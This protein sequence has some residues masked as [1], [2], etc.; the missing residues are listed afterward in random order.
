MRNLVFALR[1]LSKSPI[2]SIVAILSLALGIGANTAIFSLFEQSLLRNLPVHNPPELVNLTANGPR[3]GSNSTN[4]AGNQQSIFSYAMYRDLEKNQTVFTGIAAHRSFGAN[5]AYQGQTTS[6]SG[7]F[8]S[9]SYFPILG[10]KP[11][12]GRLLNFDDDK[13]PGSH[14][15]AVLSHR[16]W[17]EKF[18]A[19]P[20]VIGTAMVVNGVLMT[21]IGVG[22]EGFQGTTLGS[23][24]SVFVPISMREALTPGWK[25]LADR[26]SYWV[27][28]FA[29]L[30]SGT[31]MEKAQSSMQATYIG[32]IRDTELV[33]QKGMS[34]RTRKQF[35]E[36]QMTLTDGA[37]GQSG[38]LTAG[39]TPM[40]LLFAIAGFVLLIACANIANLLLARSANRAK[41]F[42]IRLSLGAS[43]SQLIVQLLCEALVLA[44]FAGI[45]GILVSYATGQVILGF[46]PTGAD[47]IFNSGIRPITVVFSMVV[48]IIAGFL[49]GLFPATHATKID[50]SAAMK[51][52]AG[53]V[54]STASASR[55]RRSLVT[56]QIALSLLLL[57]SAGMFLK[58]LTKILQVDLGMRTE[59]VIAF[60]LS[61]D[62]NQY[63]PERS[64]AF[65]EQ[66]E[67]KVAAIPGVQAAS[68]SLVGM[69]AGNN[70]GSSVSV[71][72]FE[73]GPDTDT[74]SM[75]NEV[76][77]GFFRMMN[78]PMVKGREFTASDAPSAPKV[79][80][81]NE[82]F[83]KKF[84]NG[85]SLLGRRMQQ[86][87]GGKNDIEIVG[88][89]KNVK[90]SEVKDEIPPV[91]YTPYRQDPR[92]GSSAFYIACALPADQILPS[93]R[94][95]VAEL[96]PNLP[97]EDVKTLDAQIKEN[98]GIDRMISTLAAAF[99]SL[100][101]LL[102]AV[103][104]YGVLAFTVAR[105]TREIGIRLAIGA[106][107][108]TV[109]NMILKEVVWMLAIGVLLGLPAAIA[110]MRYAE[111]LLFEIKSGDLWVLSCS[112]FVVCAV[113]L[114]AGFLPAR[115]AMQ[116]TPMEALRYE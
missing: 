71:D 16:Y 68:V 81:V 10:I 15:L 27:Y 33:L 51:D 88:V 91:F 36:Q 57:I 14:R 42:S 94:R 20:E 26:R 8:V 29:R 48:S 86:G 99:A 96:D 64:R 59:N 78:V 61:P 58:S 1:T 73:V 114:L 4:N 80:V 60:G 43:R 109:R 106:D 75:Y 93:V 87:G 77:A 97:L 7:M 35:V 74:H 56:A 34:E 24:T 112:I 90:Y 103:G 100:A 108:S 2:V 95:A 41:E 44:L 105:R 63:S 82:A 66:L 25:G 111:S 49:F 45:A 85:K 12:V 65:F 17:K 28:L 53:N 40:V 38:F 37:R 23:P 98:I 70:W 54:S 69:I 21:I 83:E 47:L 18:N 113:S 107:S 115:R 89:V 110:L 55:F 101:T 19:S 30:K 9:G 79:A 22:P 104:L 92:F 72:G 39:Q 46:L 52:Q 11:A 76:G 6:G 67:A 31:T 102:A 32:I 84:G 116:V 5:L 62:L 13:V 50:L 3:S